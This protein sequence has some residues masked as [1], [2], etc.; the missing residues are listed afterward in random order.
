MNFDSNWRIILIWF[1]F[2]LI[3]CR[4]N[5][6][7]LLDFF[8]FWNNAKELLSKFIFICVYSNSRFILLSFTRGLWFP[9]ESKSKWIKNQN[10]VNS[11]SGFSDDLI[12][13]F[14]IKSESNWIANQAS[15]SPQRNRFRKAEDFF[16]K[17]NFSY[18]L[19]YQQEISIS[20]KPK[21]IFVKSGANRLRFIWS[22]RDLGG[23]FYPFS[24]L[25]KT[26]NRSNLSLRRFF[27]PFSPRSQNANISA[28]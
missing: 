4:K 5:K 19:H 25:S 21:S 23:I 15:L 14:R 8:Q 7:R 3:H 20:R 16:T 13:S 18:E 6:L 9:S 12:D 24:H 22:E 28:F 1:W 11:D 10:K 27:E 26:Q 17:I 2:T